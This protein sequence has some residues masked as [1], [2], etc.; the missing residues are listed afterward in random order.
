PRA[1]PAPSLPLLAVPRQWHFWRDNPLF[2][3][4]KAI[5]LLNSPDARLGDLDR[6]AGRVAEVD[7]AP[8]LGPFEVRLDR[9]AGRFQPAAPVLDGGPRSG[10]AEVPLAL[11]AVRR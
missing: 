6:V 4:A 11:R 5:L 3:N 9:H 1:R 2:A 7:R 10:E 8:A